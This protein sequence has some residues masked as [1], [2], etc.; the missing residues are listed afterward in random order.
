MTQNI[1]IIIPAR[2]GSTRLPGK[3]LKLIAG[4]SMLSR[5][6]DIA[7]DAAEGL[8]HVQVAVATDHEDIIAHAE[9]CGAEAIMTD[10]T[11]KTGSDRVLQAALKMKVQPDIVINLQGDAPFTP[12]DFVRSVIDVF[13]DNPEADVAT[14]VVNLTWDALDNLREQKKTT[15]YSGT[16]CVMGKNGKAKWFSKHIIPAIRKEEKLRVNTEFSPVYRHIGLYGYRLDALKKFVTLPEG[17]FEALEGLEQLRFLENDIEIYTTT[18]DY[19]GRPA[20][21]GVDSP[22]DLARAEALLKSA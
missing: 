1:A 20:M 4:Q 6:I 12:A 7:T 18:V 14:P 8:S 10:D 9:A 5:V 13:R 2:F 3:P 16:T 21:N 19:E 22:E 15:P 17:H 11:C